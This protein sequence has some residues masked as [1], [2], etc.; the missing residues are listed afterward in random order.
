MNNVVFSA[1][2]TYF[3]QLG[4]FGYIKD[5]S[6]LKLILLAFTANFMQTFGDTMSQED[7]QK[8]DQLFMC[9]QT[10]DCLIPN[11]NYHTLCN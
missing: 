9:I 8:V 6:V 10:K 4:K 3:N 5:K 1:F 2:D 11:T 7:K